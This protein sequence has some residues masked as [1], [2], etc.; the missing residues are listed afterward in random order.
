MRKKGLGVGIL[1][2]LLSAPFFTGCN[3][4]EN[5]PTENNTQEVTSNQTEATSKNQITAKGDIVLTDNTTVNITAGGKYTIKGTAQNSS[6]YVETNDEVTL[7]LDGVN[8]VNEEGECIYITDADNM[9]II[10]ADGSENNLVSGQ[11]N[12]KIGMTNPDDNASGAVIYSK[13]KLTI[14]GNGSLTADG[15]IDNGIFSS[16]KLVINNGNIT[17]QAMNNG[18]KGKDEVTINAG[19]I[20]VANSYEGIE[21]ENV[22][23]NGGT[24][25]V[26]AYDDGINANQ[27]NKGTMPSLT[28]NGGTVK[29]DA[30][31]DGL[32]S[33]GDLIINGGEVIIDGPA[34]NGN[35]ALDSGM[36]IG[37]KLLVNGGV[38]LALGSSGMAESFDETSAQYSFIV[39][40]DN[41]FDQGDEIIIMD[42][43]GNELYKYTANKRGNSVVFSSPKLEDSKTYTLS[44]AGSETLVT[45]DGKTTSVGNRSG[46]GNGGFG[47]GGKEPGGRG[48]K[49]DR[50]DW[51][52]KPG[53][54]GMEP[55]EGFGIRRE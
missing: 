49:G 43:K 2:V 11:A 5:I 32:D 25:T 6:V 44:I 30:S 37:G 15:Y 46:F 34:N 18:L 16:K 19:N 35:G 33:N 23:I 10:L 53:D 28:I 13:K 7:V 20:T 36:E 48:E 3:K 31:G 41:S 26:K 1:V 4:G 14:E 45:L 8:L 12:E 42:D 52:Q 50:G 27:N 24:V 22:T 47:P 29:V 38:V 9:T 17:V 54:G 51:G 40:L 39:N 55:P 21:S